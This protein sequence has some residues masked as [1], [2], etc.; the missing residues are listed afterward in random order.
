MNNKDI[1]LLL[2]LLQQSVIFPMFLKATQ[3]NGNLKELNKKEANEL[4]SQFLFFK[5]GYYT[6]LPNSEEEKNG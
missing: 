2:D 1:S 4:I 6:A 5:L 3:F